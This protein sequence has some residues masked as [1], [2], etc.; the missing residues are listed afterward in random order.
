MIVVVGL[1]FEAR[2]AAASGL[3]VICAGDGR[4]LRSDLHEAIT[5]GCRGLIS[6]GVAGGLSPDLKAG[7]CVVGSGVVSSDGHV[8]T[9]RNWSRALLQAMPGAISGTLAGASGPVATPAQKHSLHCA[10]GALAVDTESHLVADAA[11][12][13]KLPMAALRVICD[14]AARTLPDIALRAIRA[15]GSTNV[16]L[17]LRE[18]LRRPDKV[19]ELLKIALDARL[20]H[21][22]LLRCRHMLGAELDTAQAD[23]FDAL[24]GV[25][26]GFS[27]VVDSRL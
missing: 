8:A 21:A 18:L 14:P 10:T 11:A 26:A 27:P 16:A 5:V 12:R 9:D 20:A 25:Q 17:L 1:A 23:E 13:R 7:T 22:T 3:Q 24:K 6:F 2:I 4:K 15:D 19:P